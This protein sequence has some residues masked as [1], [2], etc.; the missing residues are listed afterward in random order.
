MDVPRISIDEVHALTAEERDRVACDLEEVARQFRF[1]V[2]G[3][4]PADMP[5]MT[6]SA[7]PV[8]GVAVQIVCTRPK[9]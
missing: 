8:Q 9:V 5:S 7:V 3:T 2:L 4:I 6:Y 1:G